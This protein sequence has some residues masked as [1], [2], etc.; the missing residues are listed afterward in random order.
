MKKIKIP[1]YKNIDE[2]YFFIMESIELFEADKSCA[3][4]YKGLEFLIIHPETF[5]LLSKHLGKLLNQTQSVKINKIKG[6]NIIRSTDLYLSHI[7]LI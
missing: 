3:G 1:A 4:E 5:E 2:I 6:A 7:I